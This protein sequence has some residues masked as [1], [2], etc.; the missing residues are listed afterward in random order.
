MIYL[1]PIRSRKENLVPFRGDTDGD[2][3][4]EILDVSALKAV[5]LV[6]M[7]SDQ[8]IEVMTAPP[9]PASSTM[10]NSESVRPRKRAKL[11]HLT[12][13]EK[14]QHRKMMNRISAQSARDRQK[15]HIMQQD[16]SI[17]ILTVENETLKGENCSLKVKNEKLSEENISLRAR[18]EE[19]EN[20]MK[21]MSTV[22]SVGAVV[23]KEEPAPVQEVSECC[24]SF[25]P[26]VLS[27]V[28]LQKGPELQQTLAFLFLMSV[29]S[30]SI[31][32]PPKSLRHLSDLLSKSSARS[33]SL[34]TSSRLSPQQ[35][36]SER[37]IRTLQ[38]WS[39]MKADIPG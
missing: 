4:I 7:D 29:I 33:I 11:D 35:L 5:E 3:K 21:K 8:F 6:S 24:G 10:S 27:T 16:K 31:W 17:Q 32:T 38:S 1:Q 22:N 18:I 12:H 2:M 28:P 14:A 30:L 39:I 23:I 13:E 34:S 36:A 26:A 9:S 15:A 19:L 25:E 37:R 20:Q